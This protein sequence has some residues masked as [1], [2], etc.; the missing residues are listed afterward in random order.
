MWFV[1]E[2]GVLV[3][4]VRY[5]CPLWLFVG[6]TRH[7][8]LRRAGGLARNRFDLGACRLRIVDPGLVEIEGTIGHAGRRFAG[9]DLAG[10]TAMQQLEQMVL[11]LPVAARVADRADRQFGILDAH[12]FGLAFAQ[13]AAVEADNGRVAEI[14]IHAVKAGRVGDGDVDVVHPGHRFGDQHLLNLGRVHVALATHDQF[15]ALHGAVAPD[16]R[17]V[18]VV[19]DDQADFQSLGAVADVGRIA[20]IPT[21]DRRPRHDLAVLLHDL[22]LVV[23]QDQRVVRRLV[24]MFFMTLAGQREYAPDVGDAAGF[25]EHARLFAG[26]GGGGVVHFLLVVHD[27]VRRILGK[28]DKIEAGQALLHADQHGRD[29]VN[30]VHHLSAVMQARHLVIDDRHAYRVFTA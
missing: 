7:R 6:N 10:V 1:R 8:T 19:A 14:G 22:A 9:V 4:T 25:R 24:R 26:D 16:F 30:V 29:L 13:G 2:I 12:L 27:A 20:R 5:S 28:N 18:A 15:G 23:D 21:L 3:A 17:I 11:R